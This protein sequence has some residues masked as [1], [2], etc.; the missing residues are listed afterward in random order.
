MQGKKERLEAG[1]PASKESLVMCP[2]CGALIEW[3]E[4]S[5]AV[6][7]AHPPVEYPDFGPEATCSWC[8]GSLYH[9]KAESPDCALYRLTDEELWSIWEQ[10]AEMRSMVDF[11]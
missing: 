4:V 10:D 9:S 2:G 5:C 3:G 1:I 8:N 6:C 11:R 7:L